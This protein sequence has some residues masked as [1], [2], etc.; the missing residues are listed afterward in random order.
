[1]NTT[2]K[3]IDMKEKFIRKLLEKVKI[4]DEKYFE[5]YILT[6]NRDKIFLEELVN[7][8]DEGILVLD[9]DKN[10]III[11]DCAKK[12]LNIHTEDPINKP[13]EKFII[14][15]KLRIFFEKMWEFEDKSINTEI[16]L[17]YPS[18]MSIGVNIINFKSTDK[19]NSMNKIFVFSDLTDKNLKLEEMLYTEKINTF[20]LLSAGV[21]HEIGNP[22]NSLDIHM[23]L[24]ESELHGLNNPKK[25]DFLEY[26][27]IAREEINRL[28]NII[29]RFLKSI[30]PFKLNLV[31]A[32][33]I[34]TI[35][36]II[37]LMSNEICSSGINICTK[38]ERNIAPFLFDPD[39]IKQAISNIIKNSI[40]ATPIGGKINFEIISQKD[41]CKISIT[42]TGKGIPKNIIKR[43]FDPY[44]TTR[45][46]GNGLGLM[47][48]S[49]IISAH[50]GEISVISEEGKGTNIILKLP[51][52]RYGKKYL[53]EK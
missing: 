15:E 27:K 21:A 6:I 26:V 47:I 30:R 19:N 22:L 31:E 52:R 37:E 24:L 50:D 20:N 36:E 13:I 28:D 5:Y 16:T 11:N 35:S 17:D 1:M 18:K 7:L 29:K 32:D 49:R 42:D 12:I 3:R 46:D 39:Q 33:I 53:P 45:E 10:I 34:K 25:S 44:F 40:Q 48:V 2:K 38:F 14:D 4:V 41:Y 51:M 9:Q 8:L 43:I 23:Q